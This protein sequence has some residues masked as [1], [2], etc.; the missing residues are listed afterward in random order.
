MGFKVGLLRWLNSKE[1]ARQA[2]DA[3]SLSG[4]GRFPGLGY[5]NRLQYSGLETP[6]DSGAWWATAHGVAESDM[7]G[8]LS[9][10]T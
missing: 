3:G 6:M 4:L 9:T 10:H 8:P 1:S 7:T 2:G 5:G